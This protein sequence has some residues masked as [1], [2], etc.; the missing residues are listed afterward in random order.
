MRP[1]PAPTPSRAARRAPARALAAVAAAAVAGTLLAAAPPAASAAAPAAVPAAASDEPGSRFTLAVLPDTQFYSRYSADQFLPRYG[2]DPFREQ[3]RFLVEHAD[4]LNIPF[5]THLGDV[6]D[7]VGQTAEWQAADT[8]MRTL[9]EGGLPY[10]ILPG[11]HDV[12]NSDDTL[13]D[14]DYDPANEPF[15]QYFGPA[16]AATQATYGG[17][18]PTGLSQYHV[19]E[20]EGQEFMVLALAW[21]VSDQTMQWAKDAMAAHPDVPV[22]LTTHSLLNIGP[23]QT[24]PRDT[25]YGEELWDKL[26]RS[27]D[28]IFL[29]FNGH[30]HGATQ[31]TR[32]N[33]FGHSVT[34]V[35]IDYQM[36]Y[37]G[38]NGYLGLVEFDLA[39]DTVTMQTASPW[40][41]A[42][43]QETLTSYDQ[44]FLDGP[45]Q[46]FTLDLDF[47]ERFA[48]FDP[49]FGPGAGVWPSLTQRA[50]DVLLDGFVGPDPVTTE[51]PGNALDFAEAEGTVAHWRM[52]D[53]P[54]GVLPEGGTIPDVA[55][56]N[57]LT[58]ATIAASGSATAQAGDVTIVRDDVHGYSSDGAAVCFANSSAARFSYLTTASDAPVNAE[59]FP[60][61]YTIETFLQLD[62]TWDAGVN[63]WSKAVVR[64]GDRSQ[65]PGM[66][67]SQW[68]YTASP[69]ALGISNLREFQF[70]EVPIATTKGDRTAWSGEI[71][72]DSWS[73]VAIVNDPASSTTTM[74]IDG[75]PV[76]RNATDTL[77][78]SVQADMPW[79]LGSDWVDGAARNGWN[80]CIGET[81]VIDRPTGPAEWLT[82]RADL[83]GLA[84]T[85]APAGDLP[86]GAEVASLSGTGFPGAVVRVA[87]VTT[88]GG[89]QVQNAALAAA[90]AVPAS[91][92]GE[93]V[94]G[95]DGRWTL[96]YAG[97]LP[98]GRYAGSVVQALGAR[99]SA[100]VGVAFAVAAAPAPG[101]PDPVDPPVGGGTGGG[102]GAG[103]GAETGTGTGSTSAGG[104]GALATTGAE[105]SAA[106]AAALALLALGAG[107]VAL[108]RRSVRAVHED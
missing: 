50:R 30:F 38:G 96:A 43:P 91:L 69:V 51:L 58:R 85:D 70:T 41:T 79:L 61:G 46:R 98:A 12:R 55:A 76:L 100:P 47:S 72:V 102:T 93:T 52:N 65:L 81:R 27:S 18:D 84:V 13:D 17:S 22:I 101:A 10:S 73:H 78:H 15:L 6:V 19:F 88:A 49:D 26:I 1:H 9:E 44:P 48:G 63:G 16:R 75:A 29:T 99:E 107:G 14:T 39:H 25:E 7:R 42:K 37:E 71:M 23:D 33:D 66:P 57:D 34:N 105:V 59:T 40:V 104:R 28:Q 8:A 67:W 92:A 64:S 106:V 77:G 20:A 5:V 95:A 62:P 108:R 45:N 94:V 97:A 31:Q 74:Y 68:D 54:T 2:T 36:A 80:G 4:E 21:R 103:T 87:D 32:T 53:L 11:N 86:A 35:L 3:T 60:E 90:A 56:G 82:Q 24:S 83:T 89:A